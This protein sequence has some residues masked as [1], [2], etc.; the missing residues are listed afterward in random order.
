MHVLPVTK[1]DAPSVTRV[2]ASYVTKPLVLSA[3][4]GLTALTTSAPA[5][6]VTRLLAQDVTKG[7]V[8]VVTRLLAQD[9]TK[10]NVQVGTRLI[11]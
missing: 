7:N 3:T 5:R 6:I 11:A 2:G 10:G 1:T 8:Q 4:S 9:V